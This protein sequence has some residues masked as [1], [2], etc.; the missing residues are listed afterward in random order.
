ML[1]AV[2]LCLPVVF[3]ICFHLS[4]NP[5]LSAALAIALVAIGFFATAIAGYLTGIVG[6]SNNPVSGV[7]I[8]VL[9][10]IALILE[11]LGVG[12][13]IGPRLA[14]M[15]GAVVCTAAAMA[16]DS[17]HDLAT[18]YHVGATPRSLEIAVLFGATLSS[19]VMAPVL[20][21][22]IRAYGIA[23]TPS[24]HAAG[25]RSTAGLPDGE[26]GARRFPRRITDRDDCPR[27]D[28]RRACWPCSTRFWSGATRAGGRR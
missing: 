5:W 4:R 11:T 9:L 18:G 15:A 16:G 24:A 19:F 22:L 21:L 2:A 3:A 26:S 17:L 7:T 1:G 10:A 23:G 28:S 12:V 25:A 20:N 27:R 6:A 14:I 8:I 13:A